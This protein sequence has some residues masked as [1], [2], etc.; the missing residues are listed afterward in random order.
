MPKYK[1]F[2]KATAVMTAEDAGKVAGIDLTDV[3]FWRSGLEG[4]AKEVEEFG[5]L[6]KLG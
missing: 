6:C 2:L 4:L 1:S 3:N 5:E